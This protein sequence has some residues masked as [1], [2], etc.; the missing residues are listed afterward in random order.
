MR[1][2]QARQL[3]V[4]KITV[5]EKG[6]DA[7]RRELDQASQPRLNFPAFN[8]D[9]LAPMLAFGGMSIDGVSYPPF[10]P[11]AENETRY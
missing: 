3:R 7:Q 5:N 10:P 1:T 6:P 2:Q 11:L 9:S 8:N 4:A